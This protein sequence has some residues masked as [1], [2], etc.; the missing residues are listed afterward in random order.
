MS[1]AILWRHVDQVFSPFT[2]PLWL[3]FVLVFTGRWRGLGRGRGRTWRTAL[4]GCYAGFALLSVWSLGSA[5]SP[6]LYAVQRGGAWSV[7]FLAGLVVVLVVSLVLMVRH[8]R[9]SVNL[10]ELM[11]T[12]LVIAAGVITGIIGSSDLW[13]QWLMKA[14]AVSALGVL[15]ATLILAAV[16]FRFQLFDRVLSTSVALYAGGLAVIGVAGYLAV[17]R[18]VGPS[19]SL[20]IVGVTTVTVVLIVVMRNLVASFAESKA[21]LQQL[22]A[23]GRFSAQMAHDLKNPL[24]ALKGALQYLAE[25]RAQGR[26]EGDEGGLLDLS[27]EQVDRI[28][29]VI[30]KYSKLTA[31][32][33]VVEPVAVNE[34]VGSVLGLARFASDGGASGVGVKVRQ[35]FA[36]GLPDC[37]LDRALVSTGLENLV[38][39]GLEAMPDGGV[40]TVRTSAPNGISGARCFWT[41][42]VTSHW[43]CR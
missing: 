11:R 26:L 23:Y 21:R 38:R 3:H 20:L 18:L 10:E 37:L 30:E 17:V 35:E 42:S 7:A 2:A 22:A 9:A 28:E 39:N 8:L 14:P 15:A 29:V 36:E 40:L 12:R 4:I 32:E 5:F 25:E 27:V 13:D 1:G 41:R 16:V 6:G 34:V 43:R 33:P 19:A 24:A 31:V